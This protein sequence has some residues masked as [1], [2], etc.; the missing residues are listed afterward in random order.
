MSRAALVRSVS[1]CWP[2][3]IAASVECGESPPP[4]A[5][6]EETAAGGV[7]LY[8]DPLPRG[9]VSRLGTV[10]FRRQDSILDAGFLRGELMVLAPPLGLHFYEVPSGKLLRTV[11]VGTERSRTSVITP[12]GQWLAMSGLELDQ[13][14]A[15][16]DY[17][18]KLI[19]IATGD[20][21]LDVRQTESIGELLAVSDDG[22]TVAT[23]GS[24][25]GRV[26]FWDVAAESVVLDYRLDDIRI[27]TIEFAPGARL[28]AAGGRNAVALWEWDSGA[29]PKTIR[30]ADERHRQVVQS[31]VFSPDGSTLALGLDG[32]EEIVLLDVR[33]QRVVAELDGTDDGWDYIHDIAYSPDGKLLAATRNRH[34]GGGVTLWD[35]ANRKLLRTL[36]TAVEDATRLAFSPDGRHLAAGN[37]WN[38]TLDLWAVETGRRLTGN[39]PAH[40][41]RPALLQFREGGRS[42]V[43][44]GDD[45]NIR[46][47]ETATGKPTQVLVHHDA[48]SK[49]TR[50]IR[51]LALSPDGRYAAASSL[52]DTVRLWD[53]TTGRV[54]HRLPGH[55][56]LGGHR[57]LVFTPD[58]RRLL[59][60]GDDIRVC[61]WDVATGKLLQKYRLKPSGIELPDPD[62]PPSPAVE[63]ISSYLGPTAFSPDGSL[64]VGNLRKS[65]YV[66]DTETGDELL[67]LEPA[68]GSLLYLAVSPDNQHVL[69]SRWGRMVE[70]VHAD[71]RASYSAAKA[72]FI[73]LRSLKDGSMV[74]QIALPDGGAG[75]VAFSPDGSRFAVAVR[76]PEPVIHLFETASGTK[77]GVINHLPS[78]TGALA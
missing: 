56:E 17:H 57:A 36:P 59:S 33:T 23:A 49:R 39:V 50:W 46:T 16:L 66:F 45:G 53:L 44:A 21:A 11:G 26:Q 42:I 1:V 30:L 68:A 70:I 78:Y 65:V 7:D 29:E 35:S 25:T 12:D 72:H 9:A 48:D 2:L 31:M 32:D 27:Q 43:T 10:R 71:G 77:I 62:A 20:R 28:F 18:L 55:G 4:A 40:D 64:L 34:Q 52:D 63:P 13:E 37:R 51:G 61:T 6:R 19:E 5:A 60:W 54:V 38:N 74:R 3:L 41:L 24:R 58:G 69:L 15:A 8:E 67:K 73:A 76:G 14:R 22:L 47:W 75:P